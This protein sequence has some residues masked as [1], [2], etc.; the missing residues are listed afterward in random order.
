MPSQSHQTII[1]GAGLAG[2]ACA[3]KLQE[4]GQTPLLLEKSDA[5]GGRVRTDRVDG[6]LL[7]RGFQVYLDAYP[8]AGELLDLAALDLKKFEPG[9]LVFSNKGK[10]MRVMDVFRRPQYLL[11]SGLA[12]LGS[13]CDKL[14]VALLRQRCLGTSLDDLA[15][16]E[17]LTTEQFLRQFGFSDRI[18]DSFFRSFYGGIFLERELRTSSR[19]FEFTFKMFSQGS[20]TLPALG[21]EEIPRQL[22]QRLPAESIR[23]GVEIESILGNVI[24]L[25]NGDQLTAESI[26]LALPADAAQALVPALELSPPTW[27]SV[28][29]LYFS[30]PKSPLAGEPI[31]AL[32]ASGEGLVNNLSVPS[33]L[34]PNYAPK[35]KSL[36][37][38]SVLG[39]PSNPDLP[40][41]VLSEL[42]QWFGP[43]VKAWQHL[44]TDRI[45]HALPEQA[46][47]A[48][49]PANPAPPL[50]LC[51]DHQTSASIEGAIISG[52]ATAKAILAN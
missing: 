40:S 30:A 27:R 4:A 52:Q 24:T 33:D 36:I 28:S 23:C 21:M 19:M 38:V 7:D 11:S 39:L 17:D 43:E 42:T 22:A 49:A 26:V 48:K 5:V 51:G 16:H 8:T 45:P 2:L 6:F 3:L 14:R 50:Y 29:N 9:A 1:I 32:P 13:L 46:P 37:S 41:D 15:L 25:T 44:R 12:P 10:R 20:A 18:I 47:A 35:G 34:A 31:I